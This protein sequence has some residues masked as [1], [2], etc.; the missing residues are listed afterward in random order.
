MP[1]SVLPIDRRPVIGVM[2]SSKDSWDHLSSDVGRAIA[3]HDY[4]L[5]TGAGGGVMTSVA[6]AFTEVED[7]QGLSLGIV[8]VTDYTGGHLSRD[9]FPNPY[10]EIPILTP[11]RKKVQGDTNPYSRNYTNIMTSHALVFLPGEHGT[12]NEV[13]IAMMYRKPLVLFGPEEEFKT[14]PEDCIGI[15]DVN[16]LVEFLGQVSAKFRL[17]G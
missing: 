2:G 15:D 11:L 6:K 4:H 5:L 12:H 9:E 3:H 10:I 1:D 17:N 16:A 14:F 8:P 7:R 13:S